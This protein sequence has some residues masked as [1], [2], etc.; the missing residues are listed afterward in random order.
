MN[1]YPVG[2]RFDPRAPYNQPITKYRKYY[3]E[4]S[5]EL[6]TMV[7]VECEECDGEPCTDDLHIQVRKAVMEK[8]KVDGEDIVLNDLTIW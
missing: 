4:V 6:G 1:N 7:E 3:A 8:F 5:V 2:A